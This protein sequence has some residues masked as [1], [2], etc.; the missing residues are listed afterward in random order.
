MMRLTWQRQDTL[1]FS[2]IEI[3]VVISLIAILTVIGAVSYTESSKSSRDVERQGDL[4]NLQNA[5]E[6]YK[7]RNGVY[8]PQCTASGGGGWSGQMG[9]NFECT[10]GNGGQY[11]VGLAPEY[12]SVLPTD[13]RPDGANSGYVYRTNGTSYK[14]MAMNT[15]EAETVTWRHEFSSCDID[16]N[17]T[18]TS[19]IE[20][21]G[22]CTVV[23]P[24]N[25][26]PIWCEET[27]VRFQKTYAVWGG[28]SPL[29]P[30][31]LNS[32]SDIIPPISDVKKT[33]AVR[34]TTGVICQ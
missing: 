34:N 2:L 24:S 19:D 10:D 4:R 30:S 7:N 8:P 16:P 28:F 25:N 21:G 31:T 32:L 1:G 15:V 12:I 33:S 27:N 13:P 29:F 3:L 26:R 18:A 17:N 20:V 11:I 22:W 14:L 6:L 23:F 9:T 5:I